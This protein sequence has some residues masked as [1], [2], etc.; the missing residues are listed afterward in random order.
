[1]P[2]KKIARTRTQSDLTTF[3]TVTTK[4]KL[5]ANANAKAMETTNAEHAS[6]VNDATTT[7]KGTEIRQNPSKE[8]EVT[9]EGIMTA[10]NGIK[11]DLSFMKTDVS[12]KLERLRATMESVKEDI[13]ACTSRVT[14]AETR[15][16]ATE[17][18]VTVLVNKVKCL[19]KKNLSLEEKVLDLETRSRGLNVR[20][21]NLPEGAEANDACGFLEE[22][23]PEALEL[24]P[25]RRQLTVEKAHRLGPRSGRAADSAPR[26]LIMKFLSH[27]DK[28]AVMRAARTKQAAKQNILYKNQ[29]V[30][31]YQDVPS[32]IH[33]KKK[34]FDGARRQLRQMGLRHGMIPPARLIV[35]YKEHP[36]IFTSA[37]EADIFIQKIQSDTQED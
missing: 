8:P 11:S 9:L 18:D 10:I 1:M 7:T 6:D 36:Y 19:E 4:P 2:V 30:Q 28:E 31:F 23:I 35:T 14:Q 12:T 33:R 32:E 29:P 37:E 17:D 20:L 5:T 24:R 15:I 13:T 25:Q 21:V 34:E 3:A 16:S 27:K 26:T 22:W